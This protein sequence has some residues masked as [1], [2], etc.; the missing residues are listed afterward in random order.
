LPLL[1]SQ[2][3]TQKALELESRPFVLTKSH[4]FVFAA[5]LIGIG[6]RIL[7]SVETMVI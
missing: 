2:P 6:G 4:Q 3:N 5:W 1:Y 7:V